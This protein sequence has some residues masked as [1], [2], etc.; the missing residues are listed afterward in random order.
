MKNRL[1][2][3]FNKQG[4][5]AK[6]KGDQV[7]RLNGGSRPGVLHIPSVTVY[8]GGN[9]SRGGKLD[10]LAY[11]SSKKNDLNI[12]IHS[13]MQREFRGKTSLYKDVNS[14]RGGKHT[15]AQHGLRKQSNENFKKQ[16]KNKLLDYT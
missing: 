4:L 3:Q 12:L 11:Q 15:A 1:L 8:R 6:L 5:E 2:S 14:V 16:R 9:R 13:A 10:M 7:S